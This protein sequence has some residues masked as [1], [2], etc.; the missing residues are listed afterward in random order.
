MSFNHVPILLQKWVCIAPARVAMS[1]IAFL[2]NSNFMAAQLGQLPRLGT[3]VWLLKYLVVSTFFAFYAVVEYVMCSLLMRMEARISGARKRA[4]EAKSIT[5]IKKDLQQPQSETAPP[6]SD[7][8]DAITKQDIVDVGAIGFLDRAFIKSNGDMIFS[9][10]AVDNFSRIAFPLA[11][12]LAFLILW[13]GYNDT[14][15]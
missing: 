10:A 15:E 3:E 1:A 12:I 11:Y 13:F 5:T 14:E 7:G 4:Q 8:S 9:A 6:E 2:S